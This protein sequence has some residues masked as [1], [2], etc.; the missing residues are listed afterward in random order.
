MCWAEGNLMVPRIKCNRVGCRPWKLSSQ[1]QTAPGAQY[2]RPLHS[3]GHASPMYTWSI[4]QLCFSVSSPFWIQRNCVA[5]KVPQ[6]TKGIQEA[7]VSPG[8]VLSLGLGMGT[9]SEERASQTSPWGPRLAEVSEL[10][11]P[12]S[13]HI[14]HSALLEACAFSASFM[15]I[16]CSTL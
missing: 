8:C 4:A 15:W 2:P 11:P 10:C 3:L 13:G 9:T 12:D 1:M 14:P 7:V 6:R 16:S 5:L